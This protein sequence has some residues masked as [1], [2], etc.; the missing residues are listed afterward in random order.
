[1]K[2]KKSNIDQNER[3]GIVSAEGDRESTMRL[4]EQ[5]PDFMK[6]ATGNDP[7]GPDGRLR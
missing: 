3:A 6:V 4:L 7:E 5:E 1:M 2:I